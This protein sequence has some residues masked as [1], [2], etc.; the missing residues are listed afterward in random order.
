[1][2]FLTI[3]I[4]RSPAHFVKCLTGG[5]VT[6]FCTLFCESFVHA[7]V[8]RNSACLFLGNPAHFSLISDLFSTNPCFLYMKKR[9]CIPS[10]SP[11]PIPPVHPRRPTAHRACRAPKK[12]RPSLSGKRRFCHFFN[13]PVLLIYGICAQYPAPH[14][15]H[16]P[17][18]PRSA[19]STSAGKSRSRRRHMS[20]GNPP[21]C[22]QNASHRCSSCAAR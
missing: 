4:I 17:H 5:R 8:S 7:A 18:P 15:P 9:A 20:W 11:S 19:W 6:I 2:I 10:L 3:S 1:M 21:A 14:R 13:N 22:S 12:R 16:S